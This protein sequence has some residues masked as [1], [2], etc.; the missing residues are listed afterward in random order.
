MEFGI[1]N[2]NLQTNKEFYIL[3]DIKNKYPKSLLTKI[4][5]QHQKKFINYIAFVEYYAEFINKDN[6]IFQ[7]YI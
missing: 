3:Y 5:A 1:N 6:V 2:E 4:L 7:E